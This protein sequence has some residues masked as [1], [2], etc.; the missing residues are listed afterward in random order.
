M[1]P[2]KLLTKCWARYWRKEILNLQDLTEECT[3]SCHFNGFIHG[4]QLRGLLRF[5]IQRC[6]TTGIYCPPFGFTF[7]SLMSVR[8]AC[9]TVLTLFQGSTYFPCLLKS[10]FLTR[11]IICYFDW[12]SSNH[13][14]EPY[15]GDTVIISL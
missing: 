7:N 10:Y 8:C 5:N 6:L 9:H 13:I 14:I 15:F 4:F 1:F 3:L 11:S 2:C 12:L